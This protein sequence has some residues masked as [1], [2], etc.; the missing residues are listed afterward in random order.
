[1]DEDTETGTVMLMSIYEIGVEKG[2][3]VTLFDDVWTDW[4]FIQ[5]FKILKDF[6]NALKAE[7][8]Q[9]RPDIY[10]SGVCMSKTVL[11]R[12]QKLEF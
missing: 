5:M 7:F 9:Y 8:V 4:T 10:D 2:D 11:G 12:G 3:K 6:Y 1:M